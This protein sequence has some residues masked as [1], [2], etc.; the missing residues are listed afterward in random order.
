MR[1]DSGSPDQNSDPMGWEAVVK[2]VVKAGS[3]HG[4]L[5]VIWSTA[6]GF[7]ADAEGSRTA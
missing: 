1:T 5:M 2:P 4:A 3:A 7:M 6:A